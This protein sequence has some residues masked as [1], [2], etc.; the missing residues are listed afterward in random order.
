MLSISAPYRLQATIDAI[1]VW[2]PGGRI[3][4]AHQTDI[5]QRIHYTIGWKTIQIL[6]SLS[7]LSNNWAYS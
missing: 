1:S 7:V 5:S 2:I 3:R 4:N 6:R